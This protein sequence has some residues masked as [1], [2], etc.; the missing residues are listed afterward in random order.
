M[1]TS[2]MLIALI[3]A[4]MLLLGCTDSKENKLADGNNEAQVITR[5]VAQAY[6]ITNTEKEWVNCLV[7]LENQQSNVILLKNGQHVLLASGNNSKVSVN[8][9]HWLHIFSDET[10]QKTCYIQT[11]YLDPVA[12]Y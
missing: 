7:D 4:S 5:S 11:Q 2:Q 12:D 6:Q 3:T 8:D 9:V 10:K 1:K